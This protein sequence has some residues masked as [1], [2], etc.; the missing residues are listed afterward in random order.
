MVVWGRLGVVWNA[1]VKTGPGAHNTILAGNSYKMA[2]ATDLMAAL[3]AF[4]LLL[5]IL[6]RR[7]RQRQ[8]RKHR[9]WVREIFQRREQF[10]WYHTLA[11][12]LR[13]SDREYYFRWAYFSTQAKLDLPKLVLIEIICSRFTWMS[14][15]RFN[16]LLSIVGQLLELHAGSWNALWA[17]FG[18]YRVVLGRLWCFHIVFY[19]VSGRLWVVLGRPDRTRFY[20]RR[21]RNDPGRRSFWVV[22]GRLGVVSI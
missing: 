22:R 16:R 7:R 17:C 4:L 10:G 2:D 19:A 13:L 11:R 21:P 14:P 9:F 12:E 18:S 5:V 20:L 6:R 1:V 15:E 8:R 3:Q